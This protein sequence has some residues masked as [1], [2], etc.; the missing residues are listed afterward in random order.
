[1]GSLGLTNKWSSRESSIL[2]TRPKC[3]FAI[4]L[5]LNGQLAM[6]PGQ[7]SFSPPA[8]VIPMLGSKA[9]QDPCV[10]LTSSQAN[11]QKYLFA[12]SC[13]RSLSC[14]GARALLVGLSLLVGLEIPVLE[15]PQVLLSLEGLAVR[16]A[17]SH[18]GLHPYG[19]PGN[20]RSQGCDWSFKAHEFK[21]VYMLRI[22]NFERH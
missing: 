2:Q 10:H 3:W 20:V 15:A 11:S 21:A 8:K 1:M 14:L 16:E 18:Q 9:Q 12:P 5:S 7:K 6:A 22:P 17:L 4:M 13:H 19:P